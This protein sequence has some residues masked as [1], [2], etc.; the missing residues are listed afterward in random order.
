MPWKEQAIDLREVPVFFINL[1]SAHKRRADIENAIKEAGFV[2]AKRFDAV[3][4]GNIKGNA[5]S[6]KHILDTQKPPFIILEDDCR[7][8]N[9][10][11][12]IQIP[13]D[14]DA[15]YL[16]ISGFGIGSWGVGGQRESIAVP[17][18]TVI[19]RRINKDLVR[20]FNMLSSHAILFLDEIY[21]AMISK[22]CGWAYDNDVEAD[23]GYADMQKY[24]KIYAYDDPLFYQTS[25]EE[26][27]N[28]VLTEQ[29]QPALLRGPTT[30][31]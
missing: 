20:L 26:V 2:N 22:V 27:T 12:V 7:L 23:I 14:A 24:F 16:G 17:S 13:E 6:A 11:P 9:F 3:R 21:C 25:N 28:K 18:E 1:R 31:F 30:T 8:R 19:A 29:P 4:E 15:V 10:R 5:A